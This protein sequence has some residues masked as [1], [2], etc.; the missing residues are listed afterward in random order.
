MK[1][2]A[3]LSHGYLVTI[4]GTVVALTDFHVLAE[5]ADVANGNMSFETGGRGGGLF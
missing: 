1:L 3:G 4:T 5:G 2:S